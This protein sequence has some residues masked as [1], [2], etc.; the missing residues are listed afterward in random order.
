MAKPLSLKTSGLSD[1]SLL[2]ALWPY[3]KE[4]K[5]ALTLSVLLLPLIALSQAAIPIVLKQAIDEPLKQGLTDVFIGILVGFGLLLML[6]LWLRYAQMVISQRMGVRML[7]QVRQRLFE[8]LENLPLGTYQRIPLGTF[9]TRLTNDIENLSEAFA[10]SGVGLLANLASVL[11]VLGGMLWMNGPLSVLVLTMLAIL[12]VATVF[13]R[14]RARNAYDAIQQHMASL[15]SHLAESLNGIDV[16]KGF[17]REAQRSDEFAVLTEDVRRTGVASV[18]YDCSLTA[19]VEWVTYLTLTLLLLLAGLAQFAPVE[20]IHLGPI[21]LSMQQLGLSGLTAGT[22]VAFFQYVQMLFAPIEEA[23]QKWTSLQSGLASADKI[24]TLFKE[25]SNRQSDV[26]LEQKRPDSAPKGALNFQDIHFAYKAEQPVLQGLNL[27]VSPGET[28]AIV[29]QSGSGKSTLIK[30]LT[31][32]YEPTRGQLLLDEKPL[33]SY[34]RDWLRRQ[35]VVIQQEEALFSRSLADN[36]TLQFNTNPQCPKLR[37]AVRQAGAEGII[38]RFPEGFAAVLE[39]KGQNLSSGERQLLQFARAFFHDPPI[40]I[41]DEATASIDPATEVLI[42]DALDRMSQGRTVVVIAHRL[43][44]IEAADRIA[45]IQAG[46][47]KELGTHT[48]LMALGE[49]YARYQ[50]LNKSKELAI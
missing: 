5:G 36:I 28:V 23:T 20:P 34:D 35:I 30:L 32:F 29:G 6:N 44:T 47:V 41:M 21:S 3:L 48:E 7:S 37:D 4:Q 27:T 18:L 9:V 45:F 38:D 42:Q 17:N 12:L 8:H 2:A 33:S 15:N 31:R 11:G 19:S 39:E 25:P 16:I 24:W 14:N 13:L 10:N 22:L 26:P 49:Q 50:S 1:Q 43:K 40:L 46:Q